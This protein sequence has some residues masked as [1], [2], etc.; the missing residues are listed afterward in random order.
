[1]KMLKTGPLFLEI[2][3]VDLLAHTGN[4][5]ITIGFHLTS[6]SCRKGAWLDFEFAISGSTRQIPARYYLT[7][8]NMPGPEHWGLLSE[9]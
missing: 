5:I 2:L 6:T 7:V 4:P 8:D 1:M 9:S 3:R